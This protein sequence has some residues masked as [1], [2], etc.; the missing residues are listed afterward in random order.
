MD[1]FKPKTKVLNM[2]DL[3]KLIIDRVSS[4]GLLTELF[5]HFTSCFEPNPILLCIKSTLVVMYKEYN[6]QKDDEIAC[7]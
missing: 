2:N 6:C 5:L 7:H 3:A 4:V 1:G